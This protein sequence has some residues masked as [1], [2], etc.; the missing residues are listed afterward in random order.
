[1]SNKY[2]SDYAEGIP[3]LEREFLQ[4]FSEKL[5]VTIES[6][7][8][9]H[10]R[11]FSINETE[12]QLAL[13]K[14]LT[15]L[16]ALTLAACHD[17]REL[18]PE[19]SLLDHLE[20]LD[21][22]SQNRINLPKN[23]EKISN[24]KQLSLRIP[25][26]KQIPLELQ[27]LGN[28]ERL[29]LSTGSF[30]SLPNFFG[31]FQKLKNVVIGL[32]RTLNSLPSS[33]CEIKRLESLRLQDL[34]LI[35]I[36]PPNF[37]QLV[38]LQ[39]LKLSGTPVA[40]LPASLGGCTALEEIDIRDALDASDALPESIGRLSRLKSL[41]LY[42]CMLERLPDTLGDCENLEQLWLVACPKLREIPAALEMLPRLKTFMADRCP[43]LTPASKVI[44]RRLEAKFHG[45]RRAH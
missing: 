37:G 13:I 44:A 24:L 45:P 16:K 23:I 28:V 7:H 25:L 15:Q 8:V 31:S 36:F 33:I 43:K 30:Q 3:I 10:L 12:P 17:L 19:I 20:M 1:M 41:S 40:A 39:N 9:T 18:P 6:G 42:G 38:F 22:E 4:I 34:P 29:Y 35:N 11:L 2:T 14:H 5:R 26:L 27:M 32:N 21:I